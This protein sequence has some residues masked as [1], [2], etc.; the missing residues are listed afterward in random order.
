MNFRSRTRHSASLR[1]GLIT[2]AALRLNTNFRILTTPRGLKFIPV[3]S[4]A[5]AEIG[6]G[7]FNLLEADEDDANE[8][9]EDAEPLSALDAF[10]EENPGEQNGDGAVEG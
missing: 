6:R 10:A 4:F 2:V 5:Y 1:A 9:K 8:D 7:T 3:L